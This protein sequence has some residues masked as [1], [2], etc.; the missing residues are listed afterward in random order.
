[1]SVVNAIISV[2]KLSD[3]S[4]KKGAELKRCFDVAMEAAFDEVR[5][6]LQSRAQIY[7]HNLANQL[8]LPDTVLDWHPKYNNCNSFCNSLL[9]KRLFEPLFNGHGQKVDG[10][11]LY[12]ISFI[13][14][15][16]SYMGRDIKTKLDV[17]PGFVQ[18]YIQR[19]YFSRQYDADIVDSLQEYW[20]DW[21]AFG[22]PLFKHQSL[23]P[24]DCTEGYGRY[25]T[26]CGDCNLAKHVWAF[27][28]D[29]WCLTA[30]HFTREKF[31]Y[32]D[33]RDSLGAKFVRPLADQ[34]A[35][36]KNR[37][38]A[39]C[40]NSALM[41]G[42]VA[43]AQTP[44][45]VKQTEWMHSR[46]SRF[47]P[48][49]VRPLSRVRLGGIHR[50]Q[51]HSHYFEAGSRENYFE[52]PWTTWS[53]PER[54]REYKRLRRTR[55][56]MEDVPRSV[57]QSRFVKP[58]QPPKR[59]PAPFSGFEVHPRGATSYTFVTPLPDK[60]LL[61]PALGAGLVEVC[62]KEGSTQHGPACAVSCTPSCGTGCGSS[63]CASGE[64]SSTGAGNSSLCGGGGGPGGGCGGGGC[65]GGGCGGGGGC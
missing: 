18:E 28:F 26:F 36:F 64:A 59:I 32:G 63:T 30:L 3:S 5:D 50:A 43:M 56:G 58:Y 49:Y 35:W 41:R 62:N 33:E 60:N 7:L 10:N 2:A 4:N 61:F 23:F 16:D 40:A 52:A 38:R 46:K 47:A 25:P 44:L 53:V 20:Y 31:M 48:E 45:L 8:L 65:G 12:V 34:K 55:A 51:P 13:C 39:L 22:G 11:P 27:P 42:A 17:P 37:L 1:M 57:I 6:L 24:W 19:L 29:S 9:D 21:G 15:D 14:S 54:A